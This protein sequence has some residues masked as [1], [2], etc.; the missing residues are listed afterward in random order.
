TAS[1]NNAFLVTSPSSASIVSAAAAAPTSQG[2]TN[3]NVTVT[4]NGTHFSQGLTEGNF[5]DGVTIN[6]ITVTSITTAVFNVSISSTAA[7]G[8]RTIT[9]I[10]GGEFAAAANLF[11]VTA[12]TASLV[13]ITQNTGGQGQAL[14]VTIKGSNTHFTPSLTTVGFSSP[15][16]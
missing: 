7:I 8:S 4:G 16:G 14:T 12:S 10:T 5:G 2:A 9:I 11:A 13:S 15:G 1:M 6:S 3:V